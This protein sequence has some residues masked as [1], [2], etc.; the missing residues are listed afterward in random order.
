MSI[1]LTGGAG[2]IGSH[3]AVSLLEHGFEVVI[4]DN[5]SE[6]SRETVQRIRTLAGENIELTEADLT[7][8]RAVEDLFFA[9]SIQAVIH[10][11]GKKAVGDS[12]SRPLKYYRNNVAGTLNLLEAMENH[13]VKRIVFSSSA[14]VYGKNNAPPFREEMPPA[15]YKSLRPDKADD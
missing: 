4:T 13:N 11:A 6:S 1:L 10:L 8:R 2:F 15:G 5:F 9:H 14:T 7:D 12:V 3:T